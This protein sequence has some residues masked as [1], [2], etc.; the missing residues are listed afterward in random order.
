MPQF[1]P[2][3]FF[4]VLDENRSTLLYLA[5]PLVQL[6]ANDDRLKK[7]HVEAIKT[8]VSGAAPIGEEVI[9]KFLSKVPPSLKLIQGY[10][11]TE[12]GPVIAKGTGAPHT[13]TG[14]I[15]PNTQIRIVGC[16]G[17]NEGKNLGIDKVGEIYVRGPQ[18]MK[19]YHKNPKATA[20]CMEGEWFK[21][22]D[23]GCYDKSGNK[24][25]KK[26]FNFSLSNIQ[27]FI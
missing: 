3:N 16:E 18:I 8:V 10:G 13:S 24:M 6:L 9:A 17:D 27:Y 19:G 15:V 1:S 20:D 21:T 11:L 7:R 5:P 25:I 12:S 26:R 14:Y 23:L 22:G 4:K 2:E